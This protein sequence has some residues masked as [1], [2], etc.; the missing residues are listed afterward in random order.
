MSRQQADTSIA[1]AARLPT[2]TLLSQAGEAEAV[3]FMQNCLRSD[4]RG[5]PEEDTDARRGWRQLRHEEGT[6]RRQQLQCCCW[7]F[8]AVL[9]RAGMLV[10]NSKESGVGSRIRGTSRGAIAC[11]ISIT[12]EEPHEGQLITCLPLFR[13][14]ASCGTWSSGRSTAALCS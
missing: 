7:L 14:S 2:N 5:L 11:T 3:A 6:S 9:R 12:S 4:I 13:H 8:N 1:K 10:L